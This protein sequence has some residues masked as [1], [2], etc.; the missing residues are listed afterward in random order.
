M[1]RASEKGQT[2]AKE[3]R[4]CIMKSLRFTPARDDS[5][6]ALRCHTN[7]SPFPALRTVREML[8]KTAARD[9][10]ISIKP[11]I[12]ARWHFLENYR[13]AKWHKIVFCLRHRKSSF[14]GLLFFR[15][16]LMMMIP[17]ARCEL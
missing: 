6:A 9:L 10:V 3:G 12:D 11:T 17:R 4:L 1:R 8:L 16:F 15:W 13:A 5:Q 7:C 2:I 14:F